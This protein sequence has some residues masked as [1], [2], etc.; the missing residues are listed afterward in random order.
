MNN[1]NILIGIA[2][3]IF[4]VVLIFIVPSEKF[5]EVPYV[6]GSN[7]TSD[8]SSPQQLNTCAPADGNWSIPN[9][10][11]QG[12][13]ALNSPC[14]QPPDYKLAS[15]Y[16]TCANVKN[17]TVDTNTPIGRCLQQCCGYVNKP[18]QGERK[19]GGDNS[20]YDASWFPMAECA[21]SLWCNNQ[22][23][24]HFK[25][26]GTAVHYISGDLAEAHTRDTGIFMGDM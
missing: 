8:S 5:S 25:K 12:R 26:Y 23:V 16:Q 2:I 17:G 3:V 11:E 4:L 10:D 9:A 14:C 20:Q 19:Q 6:Y 22:D 1:V 13:S 24:P 18:L 15:N 7:Y 21:C